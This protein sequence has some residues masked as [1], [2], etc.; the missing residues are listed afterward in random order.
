MFHPFYITL[1]SLLYH[2]AY[3]SAEHSK[4]IGKKYEFLLK[5]KKQQHLNDFRNS[6]N[7]PY[8]IDKG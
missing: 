8:I 7:H 2:E 4:L 1:L 5:H 6:Y 3:L